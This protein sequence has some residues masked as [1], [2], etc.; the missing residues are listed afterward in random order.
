MYPTV[1]E[2]EEYKGTGMQL[3]YK[4]TCGS[5][6][7]ASSAGEQIRERCYL[8]EGTDNTG[9]FNLERV[10]ACFSCHSLPLCRV[11]TA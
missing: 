5:L 3:D 8:C 11:Q 7:T 1:Q 2:E 6:K 10:W 4:M 9:A